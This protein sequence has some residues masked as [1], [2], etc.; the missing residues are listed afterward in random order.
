MFKKAINNNNN[1][2]FSCKAYE[3]FRKMWLNGSHTAAVAFVSHAMSADDETTIWE[4]S[5]FWGVLSFAKEK[6]HCNFAN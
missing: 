4:L 6:R 2:L 3:D 5:R 1:V